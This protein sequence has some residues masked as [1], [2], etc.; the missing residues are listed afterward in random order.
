VLTQLTTDDTFVQQLVLSG[1]ITAAEARRHPQRS[2][3]TQAVQGQS[4][5]PAST[6]LHPRPGDRFLLCSD[7]LSDVVDDATIAEILLTHADLR[8]CAERMITAALR[9]GGRDNITTV[10][11]DVV[12]A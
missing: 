1:A 4:V 11:A 7:G 5:T 6:V 8:E 3:V 10:V 2:L 12:E 9:A